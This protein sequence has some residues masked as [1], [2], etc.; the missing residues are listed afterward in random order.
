MINLLYLG[1]AVLA[2]LVASAIVLLRNRRPRSVEAG[3]AE[4]SRELRALAPGPV[5]EHR[6]RQ[7]R[8]GK[9]G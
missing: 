8:V 5:D 2:S 1:I 4:F 6:P 9:P 7:R 3:V